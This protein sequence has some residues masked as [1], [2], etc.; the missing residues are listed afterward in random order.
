MWG[1]GNI[2]GK[3]FVNENIQT[4]ERIDIIVKK[5]GVP[6]PIQN[7]IQIQ[8]IC[9]SICGVPASQR[10]GQETSTPQILIQMP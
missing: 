10:A 9:M 2:E 3:I 8:V 1:N 6:I 7:R 5:V 4:L